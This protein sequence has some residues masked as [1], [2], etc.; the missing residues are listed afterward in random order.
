M[1]Y[2]VDKINTYLY[3]YLNLHMMT[4]HSFLHWQDE[5]SFDSLDLQL[6]LGWLSWLAEGKECPLWSTLNQSV[7]LCIFQY[8]LHSR[9]L[10]G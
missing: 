4:V 9:E 3:P 2:N 5:D 8:W 7:L 10:Q 1:I 6:G